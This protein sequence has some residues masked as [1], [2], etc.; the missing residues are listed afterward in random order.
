MHQLST[1]VSL[2]RLKSGLHLLLVDDNSAAK[3]KAPVGRHWLTVGA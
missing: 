3:T 1:K 2:P